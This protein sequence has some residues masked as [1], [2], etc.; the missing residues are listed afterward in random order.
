[1]VSPPPV[2]EVVAYLAGVW[3][4]LNITTIHTNGT[5]RPPNS[6]GGGTG[7]NPVGLIQYTTSGWMAANIMSST[8]S[9][10]PTNITYPGL[11][12]DSDADWAKVGKHI[13]SYAGPFSVTPWADGKNGNLTHGPLYFAQMPNWV[14]NR[15]PRNY[16]VVPAKGGKGRKREDDQLRVWAVDAE[17]WATN[18]YWKRAG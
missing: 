13:V 1:M 14:G 5:I 12:T 18:L 3:S 15:V 11:P 10:R 6:S 17:G 2:S 4:L 9:H 16:T 8:P 7:A